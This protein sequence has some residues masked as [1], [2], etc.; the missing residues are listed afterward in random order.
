MT[1]PLFFVVA[2]AVLIVLWGLDRP[3]P[4]SAY[5]R[6]HPRSRSP[7][8]A[9]PPGQSASAGGL[10]PGPPVRRDRDPR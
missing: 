8:P 9:T 6:L 1:G 3:V 4:R 2:F 7:R 5:T 10:A